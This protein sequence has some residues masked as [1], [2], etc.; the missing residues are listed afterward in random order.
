[1]I[2]LVGGNFARVFNSASKLPNSQKNLRVAPGG[3]GIRV[4]PSNQEQASTATPS[5][6]DGSEEELAAAVTTSQK[7]RRQVCHGS[8]AVFAGRFWG[9]RA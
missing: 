3:L 6:L 1:M 7:P 8:L 5:L 4:S 2:D 9:G